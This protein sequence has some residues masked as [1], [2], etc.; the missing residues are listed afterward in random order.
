MKYGAKYGTHYYGGAASLAASVNP[1]DAA[2]EG[3]SYEIDWKAQNGV[4]YQSVPLLRDQADDSAGPGK[5]SINPEAFWRRGTESWHL[6]AGQ[7]VFDREEALPYR[8]DSS[9]GVEVWDRWKLGLLDN[10]HQRHT[11]VNTNLH[12]AV[13]GDYLYF[14]DGTALRYTQ[15]VAPGGTTTTLTG[16][17]A[18]AASAITSDGFN[19]YTAHAA[20]GIYKT[21]RGAGATA[22]HLTGTATLVGYVKDRLLAAGGTSVY[23]IT[24][25]GG[26]ALPAALYTHPNTDWSW[27]GFAAG[28]THIY[29]AGRSGDKSLIYRTRIKDDGTGLDALVVGGELPDGELVTGIYGYLGFVL[30]GSDKGIRFATA[31][32]TGDLTI[33]ALVPV[34]TGSVEAFEGQDRFV[35]FGWPSFDATTSGLGRLDLQNFSDVEAL[36]PAYASDLMANRSYMAASAA[37]TAQATLTTVFGNDINGWVRLNNTDWT[38]GGFGSTLLGEYLGPGNL[39]WAFG[40][41]TSGNLTFTYSQNGTTDT[42]RASTVATG[43]ADNTEQYVGFAFDGDNG[44]A[45]HDVR[46]HTWAPGGTPTL[47]G[48]VVTNAGVVTLYNGTAPLKVLPVDGIPFT[49]KV[50]EAFAGN[51]ATINTSPVAHAKFIEQGAG[52][53]SFPDAYG[54]LWTTSSGDSL[55]ADPTAGAVKAVVTFQGRRVFSVAGQG[56]FAQNPDVLVPE[57]HLDTG[58]VTFNLAEP[59]I[60]LSGDIV[61]TGSRELWMAVDGGAFVQ[62]GAQDGEAMPFPTG[63]A[64]GSD[65]E[66]RF[67]LKRSSIDSDVGAVV[68]AWSL[69]SQP[70]TERTT[71]ILAPLL[72]APVISKADAYHPYDSYGSWDHIVDL[73]ETRRVVQWQLGARAHAVIVDDYDL[74][75]EDTF[76]STYDGINGTCLVKMKVVA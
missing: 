62:L 55:L 67:V 74:L 40:I 9:K 29:A 64:K 68:S 19:V 3:R 44:A 47:L 16:A 17:P 69:L 32:S 43:L 52:T 38:P 54:N 49:G 72:I 26:P 65:F 57:G 36:A 13:A 22:V 46:F 71:L 31:G 18:T 2:L 70:T 24:T 8:F 37:S 58:E 10:T 39:S 75:I 48:A 11:S 23:D 35:W 66:L 1:L 41:T 61:A 6:G 63:T 15:N 7:S 21:T 5:Q 60:S 76:E 73:A 4:R 28:D 14:C 33:G 12:M 34:G 51:S 59:K 20:N 30:I 56:L 50:Y 25:A 53:T 42:T 27:V 45:G